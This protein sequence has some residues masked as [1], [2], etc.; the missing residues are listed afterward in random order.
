MLAPAEIDCQRI[1]TQ[2]MKRC[3]PFHGLSSFL[4]RVILG[5]A[6]PGFMLT[7]ASQAK[8][9]NPTEGTTHAKETGAQKKTGARWLKPS[10]AVV[11]FRRSN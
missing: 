8:K 2:K 7:P 3:R 6:P 10:R 11:S 4:L 9:E 5:L 1:N